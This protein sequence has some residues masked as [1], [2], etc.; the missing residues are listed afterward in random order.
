MPQNS[1]K[2]YVK[3][4]KISQR[5]LE[6]IM[7]E[8]A[9]RPAESY[10]PYGTLQPNYI[11]DRPQVPA[12]LTESE[13]FGGITT[14]DAVQRALANNAE[15]E[16]R[17]LQQIANVVQ[18]AAQPTYLNRASYLGQ[19]SKQIAAAGAGASEFFGK[20]AGDI[21]SGAYANAVKA[22]F[23]DMEW[24]QALRSAGGEDSETVT[25][26][27]DAIYRRKVLTVDEETGKKVLKEVDTPL[28]DLSDAE[29]STL[30]IND[31][32]HADGTELTKEQQEL[33]FRYRRYNDALV[34]D[35]I[36]I[37]AGQIFG[38]D[39]NDWWRTKINTDDNPWL[40]QTGT[41]TKGDAESQKWGAL[42]GQAGASIALF[43]IVGGM[44]AG[45]VANAAVKGSTTAAKALNMTKF[46]KSM[47]T[48]YGPLLNS[49]A[50]TLGQAGVYGTSFWTQYYDLRG[51][52]L[53]NGLSL[54]EAN[55]MAFIGGLAE[56]GWESWGFQH[57]KKFLLGKPSILNILFQDVIP[58]GSQE[59]M[60][61]LSENAVT[62]FYG[63]N[64]K[65][66]SDIAAEL[67]ISFAA[68]GIG[69]GVIGGFHYAGNKFAYAAEGIRAREVQERKDI[70]TKY[71]NWIKQTNP[72]ADKTKTSTEP[73]AT[74]AGQNEIITAE[75]G[76]QFVRGEDG[77]LQTAIVPT[78][79]PM[80]M[81]QRTEE[82][83]VGEAEEA[84]MVEELDSLSKA[85]E[86]KEQKIEDTRIKNADIAQ[87]MANLDQ[88]VM[89]QYKELYYGMAKAANKK[90][91]QKQLDNGWHAVQRVIEHEASTG[92]ITSTLQNATERYLSAL[93]FADETAAKNIEALKE[94]LKGGTDIN[95]NF[96]ALLSSNADERYEAQWEY[97][98]KMIEYDFAMNGAPETG[99]TVAAVFRNIF[100]KTLL[101]SPEMT[102]MDMYEAFK[103]TIVSFRRAQINNQPITGVKSIL[104]DVIDRTAETDPVDAKE[105][106][107]T[108]ASLFNDYRYAKTEEE[109]TNIANKIQAE[110]FQNVDK[111]ADVQK[112]IQT[113]ASLANEE[114]A[115]AREMGIAWGKG[116]AAGDYLLMAIM[117]SQGY[118]QKDISDAWNLNQESPN[119]SYTQAVK[120]LFPELSE[121]E[122]SQLESMLSLMGDENASGVYVT[123][124][125][126][127]ELEENE[128]VISLAEGA[129]EKVALEEAAHWFY[130]ILDRLGNMAMVPTNLGQNAELPIM[131]LKNAIDKQIRLRRGNKTQITPTMVQ[132]TFADFFVQYDINNK[133]DV[134]QDLVKA[135][136]DLIAQYNERVRQTHPDSMRGQMTAQAK[137]GLE[138]QIQ[139]LFKPAK[140]TQRLALAKQ[141]DMKIGSAKDAEELAME[142]SYAISLANI[143]GELN[144]VSQL[145][146]G[147][148]NGTLDYVDVAALAM[149]VANTQRVMALNQILDSVAKLKNGHYEFDVDM[150]NAIADED[151][152]NFTKEDGIFYSKPAET[153]LKKATPA[154]QG[155]SLQEKAR[156][157]VQQ[158][159]PASAT[160]AAKEIGETLVHAAKKAHP[161]LA[162]IIQRN[163]FNLSKRILW[164]ERLHYE[165][166]H[167]ITT[168]N[169]NAE[170]KGIGEVIND[171]EWEKYSLLL[172]NNYRKKAAKMWENFFVEGE[173]RNKARQLFDSAITAIDSVYD[174]LV[175]LGVKID[176]INGYWPPIVKDVDG[177]NMKLW[178][179][180]GRKGEAPQKGSEISKKMNRMAREGKTI[181][182]IIDAVGGM[183]QKNPADKEVSAFHQRILKY[184][185]ID[186]VKYYKDPIDSMMIYL[187][188]AARTV[189]MR[190]LFGKLQTD[191]AGNVEW[192]KTGLLPSFLIMAKTKKGQN[193]FGKIDPE[194]E[195]NLMRR[196]HQFLKREGSDQDLWEGMRALQGI[197]ALGNVANAVNQFLE[198]AP[199]MEQFG[200]RNVVKAMSTI[201]AKSNLINVEIANVQ[202][203][204][205]SIR[206]DREGIL[207]D[208]QD[209]V[210]KATGFA[211]A[212][213][214]M[215]NIVLNAALIHAQGVLANWDEKNPSMS[216]KR[217]ERYF[218]ETF[219]PE[220]TSQEKIDQVK[221]DMLAGNITDDVAFFCRNALARTQ[222]ID[223]TE[224]AANYNA[225]GTFGRACYYL[226]T[227]SLKQ[228]Q[229]LIDDF[230]SN[231]KEAN[232]GQAVKEFAKFLW[233]A[234]LI[235]VPVEV[236][237][238]F[239]LGKK[240]DMKSAIIFSP[241]QYF[242]INE[243]YWNTA[244]DRGLWTAF[245][246]RMMPGF[247][248]ADDL[249]KDI[250]YSGQLGWKGR[251]HFLNSIPII[252]RQM[253]NF[254]GGGAEQLKKRK[255]SIG[256]TFEDNLNFFGDNTYS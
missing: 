137:K 5:G 133:P 118:N 218:K 123:A 128:Q 193:T 10:T 255:E 70:Q 168:H 99:K 178:E 163:A 199:A 23:A 22:N 117:R 197:T 221:K 35:K 4:A 96:D 103:P 194:A 148:N 184:K 179:L 145:I 65:T 27:R 73:S 42:A 113:Y 245:G 209:D 127:E 7:A 177:L 214:F 155:K 237:T 212:D 144:T 195:S 167:L 32:K 19:A 219:P 187:K 8:D 3:P 76:Q 241:A 110:L 104:N 207:K 107:N 150:E 112:I 256:Y 238:A 115:L 234:L 51:Q 64:D 46:A 181:Q 16:V 243:Y 67:A 48:T 200:F 105:A 139:A 242:L 210:M 36:S 183:M 49:M 25:G 135:Y 180:S 172:F 50:A 91:T 253:Y 75:N 68:G 132:E 138:K 11:G 106:A 142:I 124:R 203:L 71:D 136:N 216:Q 30:K 154:R 215:K 161:I 170:E 211:K 24:A 69:G 92:E 33:F 223:S 171:A 1:K 141:L 222:P 31:L 165:M 43:Q 116:L 134:P 45:T 66:L 156:E 61:T 226:T 111:N 176:K 146:A 6:A 191:E 152:Y 235:G 190:Q 63:I 246:E 159:S 206:L 57:M 204:N 186:L 189:F 34:A 239:L 192:G 188:S 39:F 225:M 28:V 173:E 158:F 151:R 13:R 80:G 143:P 232:K 40:L 153:A 89:D 108:L 149:Q 236:I 98:Q 44:T 230:K 244:K 208:I 205:E 147:I 198:L 240:P 97:A 102:P 224:I 254:L 56:A 74:N 95:V 2:D 100:E 166:D 252:G 87:E 140:E 78:V 157:T 125:P 231:L 93:K 72:F 21:S 58:E 79:I 213:V 55:R 86:E 41:T 169:K 37:M 233:F 84:E 14:Q 81:E 227:V 220:I 52:A 196:V 131:R 114:Y 201:M 185:T 162:N 250:M 29:I 83:E 122:L 82:T 62:S 12:I 164:A 121:M 109:K 249:W 160:K 217:F 126:E 9:N 129:K 85:A 229:W 174:E 101:L 17:R 60:Q 54:S 20:I 47:Q 26:L 18:Q 248:I 247:R 38:Q 53:M 94:K 182:D 119:K 77:E 90:I 15:E 228:I 202:L 88:K 175:A 59:F 251:T 130:D 120:K